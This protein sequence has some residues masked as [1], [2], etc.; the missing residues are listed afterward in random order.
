[1][2]IEFR[3]CRGDE[4][5]AAFAPLWHYF[6]R[7]VSDDD[8]RRLGRI[9]PADRV[10]A[11]WDEG[12]AVGG[13]GAYAFEMSVPGGA[14]V[15]TAGVMAVGVLPTHRRRGILTELMRRQ[16]GDVHARGEPLAM[17]Y[18]SE[19]AIYGRYGYGIASFCGEMQLARER[20]RFHAAFEPRATIR[21]VGEEEALELFPPIYERVRAQRA[22]MLSRTPE[23]WEVRRFRPRMLSSGGENVC[24]V[25]ELDGEPQAYA[26][27][28]LTWGVDHGASAT[29]LQVVEALGTSAEATCEVWRYLFD[30]DWIETIAADFLPLDHPLFFLLEEPRRMRFELG[31]ALWVRLVDIG[32]ALSARAY[33]TE[34][35]VVLDVRDEF[36]PWN[37]G[38]SRVAAG[39]AERTDADAGLRLNARELGSVYLGGVTFDQL[40]GAGRVH[41]LE[42]GTLARADE[43]FRTP[44]QPW[45]PELF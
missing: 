15:P 9:L 21:L 42:P 41:E 27:Y 5:G 6:G 44:R 43:L 1:M 11:A 40:A 2:A 29:T 38:R 34:G 7:S 23:W 20:A 37:A 13:A 36:C 45:C 8:V 31:E 33:A 39:Q 10:Y 32:A 18:A 25:V 16:L 12:V 19:G 35:E 3:A 4:L 17:L 28:R 30:V 14:S 26:I 24:V 22:G